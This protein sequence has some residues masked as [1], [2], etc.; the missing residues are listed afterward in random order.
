MVEVREGGIGPGDVGLR[1]KGSRR[2][3]EMKTRSPASMSGNTRGPCR[4]CEYRKRNRM[5]EGREYS[6]MDIL[7]SRVLEMRHPCGGVK[8]PAG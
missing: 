8:T 6:V 7:W 3:C 4:A 1:K 2:V 5:G